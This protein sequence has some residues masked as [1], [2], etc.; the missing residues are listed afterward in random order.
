MVLGNS[1]IPSFKHRKSL[2]GS[3]TKRP[4]RKVRVTAQ[5]VDQDKFVDG[6]SDGLDRMLDHLALAVP[7]RHVRHKCLPC[8]ALLPHSPQALDHPLAQ[9]LERTEAI[10]AGE[11]EWTLAGLALKAD[12][13]IERDVEP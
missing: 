12:R 13:V 6:P 1:V 11:H 2:T 3:Y 4:A 8:P 10:A 9:R 7:K 5:A